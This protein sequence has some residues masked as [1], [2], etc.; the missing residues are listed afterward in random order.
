MTRSTVKWAAACVVVGAT[1]AASAGPARGQFFP[2]ARPGVFYNSPFGAYSLTYSQQ[3]SFSYGFV[4]PFTGVPYSYR[5]GSTYAGPPPGLGGF[6]GYSRPSYSPYA[7]GGA[8]YQPTITPRAGAFNP[9]AR[10]QVRAFAAAANQPPPPRR[11][12]AGPVPG[13]VNPAAGPRKPAAE[14]KGKPVEADAKLVNP[15]DEEILSGKALNQRAAAIRDLEAKGAKA[16]PPL[17]P[18]D[19]LGQVTF[20]GSP[21]AETIAMLRNGVP[22]LPEILQRQEFLVCRKDIER[23]LAA[24]AEPM[25]QGKPAPPADVDGLA[26]AARKCRENDGIRDLP[27]PDAAVV[28]RFLDGLDAVTRTARDAD[29]AGVVVPKWNLVGATAMELVRHTG[30][31]KL[32]FGPAAG[33]SA[34]AYR[35]L[36]RGL[37]AYYTALAANGVKT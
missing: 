11:L 28:T 5:F 19:V 29:L 27:V 14:N 2:G 32:T 34:D 37:V 6:G 12:A 8:V 30:R 15:A 13:A 26:Q 10:A 21:A 33:G 18:A 7:Y 22:P 9:V 3:M 36:H 20:V 4:N 23:H 31:Y 35:A 25:S 1:W 17:L 24:V 16:D